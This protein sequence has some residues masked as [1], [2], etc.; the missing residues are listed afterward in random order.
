MLEGIQNST[1]YIKKRIGDFVP[2]CG[3]ILGTGLGALVN[4]IEIEKTADV[5]QYPRFPDVYAR[6]PFG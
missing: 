4:E 3:I 1:N 5:Q 2:E 6:I